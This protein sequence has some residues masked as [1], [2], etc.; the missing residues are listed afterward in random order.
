[1]ARSSWHWKANSSRSAADARA[2]FTL[3]ELLI[4]VMIIGILAAV[5]VPKLEEARERAKYATLKSV[6]HS[7]AAQQEI[8]YNRFGRY[9]SAVSALEFEAGT[10][11]HIADPTLSGGADG[12]QGWTATATHDALPASSGCVIYD[13]MVSGPVTGVGAT[14]T[15][16]GIPFCADD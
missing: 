9:S 6:L 3:I 4:V 16:A 8:Y 15:R 11:I 10:G 12:Q 2:G 14:A 13:G 5:A 1:M 7:M